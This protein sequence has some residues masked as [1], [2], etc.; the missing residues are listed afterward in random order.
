MFY[1]IFSTNNSRK[2]VGVNLVQLCKLL[3][4]GLIRTFE[5]VTIE[6]HFVFDAITL[7]DT[8]TCAPIAAC[9]LVATPIVPNYNLGKHFE[10]VAF[11]RH[12]DDLDVIF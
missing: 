9:K 6:L 5:G 12:F 10:A 4:E 8:I 1:N 11:K 3:V 7:P 2:F